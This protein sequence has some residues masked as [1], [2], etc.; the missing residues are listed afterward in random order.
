M[1]KFITIL[2]CILA[3]PHT[4]FSATPPVDPNVE[5]VRFFTK[6]AKM[7]DTLFLSAKDAFAAADSLK[8]TEMI[9][10]MLSYSGA[11]RVVV[12]SATNSTVWYLLD[13][14]LLRNEWN[15]E[16]N[17]IH[18]YNYAQV[19]RYGADKWFF[20][21]GGD[22]SFSSVI[23]IGVNG[24]IGAYLW[25]RFIDAAL[26]LNIGYSGGGG[27][28]YWN[29]SANL[30]SRVYFTRFFS[31]SPLSP[32]AGIGVGYVICPD[33]NFDPLAIAGVNW[34]LSRGSI[35]FSIQY[36]KSSKFGITAGY[37]ISF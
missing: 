29:I 26:G 23:T 12:E 9:R 33:V 2:I 4:A 32:F 25:K 24:R 1:R 21:F 30:T 8:Q 18:E 35:D 31:K 10:H 15:T 6:A 16:K 19:N 13:R 11:R 14:R 27:A 36:G 5:A 20:T 22:M 17:L 34:Y 7:D 37:T 3:L 28:D